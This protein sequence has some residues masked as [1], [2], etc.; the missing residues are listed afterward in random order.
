MTVDG[1]KKT[2]ERPISYTGGDEYAHRSGQGDF[3]M[4]RSVRISAIAGF[5]QKGADQGSSE[6]Y[7]RSTQEHKRRGHCY[8]VDAKRAPQRKGPPQTLFPEI[9]LSTVMDWMF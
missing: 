2:V 6:K 7:R 4:E 8:P 5:R 3:T 1:L 9:V